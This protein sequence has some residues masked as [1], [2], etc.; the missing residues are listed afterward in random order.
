MESVRLDKLLAMEI[1]R[2]LS[3]HIGYNISILNRE[4]VIIASRN[5]DRM[6]TFNEAA[7]RLVVAGSTVESISPGDRLPAGATP[8]IYLPIVYRGETIGVVG[9]KG[10][11]KE[12]EPVAY[13]V[14]TSVETMVEHEL[15]KEHTIRQLDTKNLFLNYLL[16]EDE[17]PRTVVE[18]LA[19][20]L[21]YKPALHRVPILMR[22]PEGINADQVLAVVQRNGIHTPQDISYVTLDGALLVFKT[23]RFSGP[24]IVSEYEAQASEYVAST[25]AAAR[26]RCG[27]ELSRACVGS[28]QKD[29]RYYRAAYRQVLWLAGHISD[30]PPEATPVFFYYYVLEYLTSRVARPE[31]C[32][33]FGATVDLL[34]TDFVR[35]M[36]D[37]VEALQESAFNAKEAASR[38]SIH[39]NTLTA[40]LE[41]MREVFGVDLRWNA[42]ARDFLSMLARYLR[43]PGASAESK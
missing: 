17:T 42:P 12:V 9:V 38:L 28:Y 11:P 43:L 19:A 22:L 27:L 32:Q 2:R 37:S 10:D 23:I 20:K 29:F 1:I 33:I 6:G 5:G 30:R 39:R 14:K 18:G 25:S 34:P 21:G 41:R 35:I 7:Y 31:L 15:F 40:R 3:E 36:R 8:G 26:S 4:G 13:A 24:G 16:Y